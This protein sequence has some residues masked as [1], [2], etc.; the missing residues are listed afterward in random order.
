S[1]Q[2]AADA[3]RGPVPQLMFDHVGPASLETHTVIYERDGA[4]RHGV[5]IARTP[6]GGRLLAR[7]DPSDAGTL[8]VL[9]DLDRTAVGREGMVTRGDDGIAQWSVTP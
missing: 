8:S 2:H 7:V 1:V 3:R 5:V 6:G 4:P 9:T